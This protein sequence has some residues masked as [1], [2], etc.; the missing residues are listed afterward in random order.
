MREGEW[1]KGVPFGNM[2]KEKGR[3]KFHSEIWRMEK[4]EN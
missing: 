1:G 3:N 4:E 2:G